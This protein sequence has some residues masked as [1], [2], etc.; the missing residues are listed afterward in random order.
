MERPSW[1]EYFMKIVDATALRATCDRGKS[2]AIITKEN[3]ILSAGYVG[4]PSG[5]PHC[6]DIGHTMRHIVEKRENGLISHEGSHCISTVH[7][8]ANAICNAARSGV[9]TKG[10]TIYCTMMPCLQC[11]KLIIQS[12]IVVVVAKY[13]YHHSNESVELFRALDMKIKLMHDKNNYNV[14]IDKLRGSIGRIV[15][16]VKVVNVALG[17]A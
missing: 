7:A 3:R 10:A 15:D 14:G 12:G 8:E 11:A 13:N 17:E 9:S 5:V 4:N 16:Q 6:D 1:D 2:A